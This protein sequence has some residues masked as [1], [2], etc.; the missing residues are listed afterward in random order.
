MRDREYSFLE[1]LM[2]KAGRQYVIGRKTLV[3]GL[4]FSAPII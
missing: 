4:I 3:P 1:S 2:G